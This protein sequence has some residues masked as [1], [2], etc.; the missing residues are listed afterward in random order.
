MGKRSKVLGLP[1]AVKKWLDESLVE[2]NFS[3]YEAFA[4]ELQGKGFDISR[5][6]LHRYGADLERSLLA[7]KLASEQAR[8]LNEAA[9]DDGNE[10][11]DALLR[12]VQQ[13]A[14]MSLVKMGEESVDKTSFSSLAKIAAETGFAST[15]VKEFR[16]KVRDRAKA[17]AAEVAS[18]VKSA[19]LTDEAAKQIQRQIL[20]IAE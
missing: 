2:G 5:S 9:N 18:I 8:A 7:V 16:G 14:F 17:A 13:K 4:A 15:T 10:L 19:G 20:G 11:G 6:S 3:G 12:V 1:A